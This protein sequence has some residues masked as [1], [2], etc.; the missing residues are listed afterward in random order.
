MPVGE[1]AFAPVDGFAFLEG[2]AAGRSPSG[3]GIGVAPAGSDRVVEEGSDA[4]DFI[5]PGAGGDRGAPVFLVGAQ[6][7]SGGGGEVGNCPATVVVMRR[8]A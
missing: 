3:S 5:V 4:A 2:V 1:E 6:F 7:L 8:R